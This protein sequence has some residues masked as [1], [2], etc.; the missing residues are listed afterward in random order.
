M[1]QIHCAR[2]PP[3]LNGVYYLPGNLISPSLTTPKVHATQ[4]LPWSATPAGSAPEFLGKHSRVVQILGEIRDG[5][6][7]LHGK[8]GKLCLCQGRVFRHSAISSLRTANLVHRV[9]VLLFSCIPVV[10]YLIIRIRIALTF[11][12]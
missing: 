1:G 8:N 4:P 5:G 6:G 7:R 9:H 2:P 11:F 3:H 10:C 12:V